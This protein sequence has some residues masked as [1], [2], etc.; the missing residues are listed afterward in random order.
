[1]IWKFNH[2]RQLEDREILC[3]CF[4]VVDVDNACG[5][6]VCRTRNLSRLLNSVVSRFGLVKID[7]EHVEAVE[8]VEVLDFVEVRQHANCWLDHS[9]FLK[10]QWSPLYIHSGEETC[11]LL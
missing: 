9:S 7:V 5:D 10:K 4:S 3:R 8:V 2:R 1:M 6:G 11:W